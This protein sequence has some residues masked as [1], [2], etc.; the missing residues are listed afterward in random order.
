MHFP[1]FLAGGKRERAGLLGSKSTT[2]ANAVS[3]H[4]Y[5]AFCLSKAASHVI[6]TAFLLNVQQGLS[7]NLTDK[8]MQSQDFDVFKV[9]SEERDRM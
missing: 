7:T 3:P 8:R 1:E 4:V 5:I 2:R 9:P 6:S